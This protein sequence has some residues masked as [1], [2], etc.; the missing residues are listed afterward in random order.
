MGTIKT[1]EDIQSWQAAR[2]VRV[3]V[4]KFIDAGRFKRNYRLIHQIEGASGSIMDNIA[5]GFERGT[6]SEF[7]MFLGY[8]KGSCGELRS[9]LHRAF[10]RSCITEVEF[11]ELKNA[12][13][14]ISG[15]LQNLIKY[16][17]QCEVA[18]IRKKLAPKE[19]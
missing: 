3:R 18:G 5:E 16:L 14:K 11:E 10:D 4:G 6:R 1:F 13:L 9:Q 8:A 15:L 7:I 17:Q 12:V 2:S 19:L